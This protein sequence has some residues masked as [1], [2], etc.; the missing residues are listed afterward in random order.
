MSVAIYKL[1]KIKNDDMTVGF[2]DFQLEDGKHVISVE[3]MSFDPE[4][5][6]TIKYTETGFNRK[7]M[8]HRLFKKIFKKS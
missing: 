1:N 8:T 3:R 4:L 5:P 7:K 2:M 6:A